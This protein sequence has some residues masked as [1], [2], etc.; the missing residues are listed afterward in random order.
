MDTEHQALAKY[1]GDVFENKLDQKLDQSLKNQSKDIFS[2]MDQRFDYVDEQLKDV[3]RNIHNLSLH[4]DRKNDE[5]DEEFGD[6]LAEHKYRISA[7]E[8]D[9]QILTS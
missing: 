6:Q 5:Q 1:L 7:L 9:F 2:Y 4:V 8:S 3:N